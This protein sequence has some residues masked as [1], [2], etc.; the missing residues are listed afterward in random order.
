MDLHFMKIFALLSKC[1]MMCMC[2]QRHWKGSSSGHVRVL[3]IVQSKNVVISM[4]GI[5]ITAVEVLQADT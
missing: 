1:F 5:T 2:M 3:N 4:I